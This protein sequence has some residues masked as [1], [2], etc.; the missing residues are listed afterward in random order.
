[1]SEVV[2]PEDR[3]AEKQEYFSR[4]GTNQLAETLENA[5]EAARYW[6]NTKEDV[7][8]QHLNRLI[9]AEAARRELAKRKLE[10]AQWRAE[11]VRH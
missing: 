8:A 2:L 7:E 5:L 1:M 10:E 4:F 3:V 11:D 6:A 9:E